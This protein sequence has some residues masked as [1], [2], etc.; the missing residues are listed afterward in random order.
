M[1]LTIILQ[2]AGLMHLGLL[3]AGVLMPGV[4]GLRAH[5]APLPPFIRQLVWVYYTFIGFSL[6]SFGCVSFF[7]S[8]AL[9]SG[10]PL[11]R[12]VCAFLAGFWLLRLIVATFVFDLRPYLTNGWRR[13]GYHATNIVFAVLPVAYA[14]A[15][16]N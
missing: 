10:E 3:G 6:V 11:A 8:D 2:L 13:V 16:W 5:L 9:A 12:A 4:V 14:W 7:L 15:A 1:K